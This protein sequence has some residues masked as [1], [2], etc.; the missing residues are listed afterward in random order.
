MKKNV[1]GKKISFF[2]SFFLLFSFLIVYFDV[3][4]CRLLIASFFFC[5]EFVIISTYPLIGLFNSYNN[6]KLDLTSVLFHFL[7]SFVVVE[8]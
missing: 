6:N 4:A 8:T 1:H 3:F 2:L 5:L 7:S